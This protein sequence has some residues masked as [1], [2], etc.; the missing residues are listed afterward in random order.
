[1]SPNYQENNMKRALGWFS[2][3]LYNFI[4][5]YVALSQNMGHKNRYI[6]LKSNCIL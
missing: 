6:V 5:L 3:K 1:M 4:F 2:L